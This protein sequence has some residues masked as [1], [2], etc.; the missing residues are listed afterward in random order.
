MLK[1]NPFKQNAL[2]A[3][4]GHFLLVLTCLIKPSSN[5]KTGDAIQSYFLD[6][7]K[8]I[9]EPKVFGSKCADCEAVDY[10]YVTN[11]K[12]SVRRATKKL[13]NGE[14][15]SYKLVSFS[16]MLDVLEKNRKRI[17]IGTYGDPSIMKFDDLGL[18]CEKSSWLSYTHFWTSI[19]PIYSQ[20]M[21]ASTSNIGQDLLAN[22][23]GYRYFRVRLN[24]DDPILDNAVQCPYETHNRQCVQCGLCDGTKLTTRANRKNIWVYAHG[25][26]ANKQFNTIIT[27]E[28]SLKNESN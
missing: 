6:T 8:L 2:V 4:F 16:V 10:C 25:S 13:I 3:D 5:D 1:F 24:Y 21:M 20:I 9:K 18:I 15:T 27:H 19:D 22:N 11:D 12:Q 26:L 17:R 28:K 23:I 14:K 7:A